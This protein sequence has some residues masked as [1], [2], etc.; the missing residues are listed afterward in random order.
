MSDSEDR[1][2]IPAGVAPDKDAERPA[3]LDEREAQ[4][5]AAMETAGEEFTAAFMKYVGAV[6]THHG[7]VEWRSGFD[8][9][10]D[11]SRAY[12]EEKMEEMKK[13]FK[14][15]LQSGRFDVPAQFLEF[16]TP[17]FGQPVSPPMTMPT[18]NDLVHQF[19]HENPGKRGV[20]IANNFEKHIF[21]L[22]ERTVR[23]A[24]HRL[25]K[26]GKIVVVDGFW[27]EPDAAPESRRQLKLSHEGV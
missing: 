26:A 19:I 17:N 16:G 8:A 24:L 4:Y 3:T 9:G 1:S 7:L 22:P 6:R 27:Y 25:K 20:E 10:W 11:A 2:E 13:S 5:K 15:D 12:M 14:T 21:R 23:T 18:A